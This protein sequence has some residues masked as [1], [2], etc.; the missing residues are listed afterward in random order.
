MYQTGNCYK[1][2]KMLSFFLLSKQYDQY[3]QQINKLCT[4]ATHTHTH[5]L[6]QINVM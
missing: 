4:R 6:I 2:T 5:T 3:H 1:V